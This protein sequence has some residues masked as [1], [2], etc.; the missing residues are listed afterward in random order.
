MAKGIYKRIYPVW[1]KGLKNPFSKEVIEKMRKSHLGLKQTEEHIRNAAKTR[2]GRKRSPESI[3]KTRLAHIGRKVSD[4]QK[5]KQR[6]TMTG[7]ITSDAIKKKISDSLKGKKKP[8]R[9][10]IH[11]QRIREWVVAHPNKKFGDTKIELKVEEEL[12]K[13]QIL[14]KKHFPLYGIANVD[15]YLPGYDCVIQC[16]GCYWHN[17]LLHCPNNHIGSRDRDE[18]QDIILEENGIKVHRLWEHEINHPEIKVNRQGINIDMV[19]NSIIN[20]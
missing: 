17:C 6:I 19:L 15:F 2:I 5:E 14:Y 1:N 11:K 8:P 7:R 13:R 16:D 9:S 18:R 4:E 3:E 10:E 20:N 12:K